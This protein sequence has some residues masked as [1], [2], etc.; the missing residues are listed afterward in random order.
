MF[1]FPENP[2]SIRQCWESAEKL[3]KFLIPTI[4]VT[5]IISV[6]WWVLPYFIL[7]R[8]NTSQIHIINRIIVENILF[9]PIYFL[10]ILYLIAMIYNQ[11]KFAIRGEKPT[12]SHLLLLSAKGLLKLIPALLIALILAAGG[13]ILLIVPGIYVTLALIIYYP[14]IIIDD[15]D[16][17]T[18]MRHVLELIKNHWWFT[19]GVIGIPVLAF[20]GIVIVI[21]HYTIG[22][23]MNAINNTVSLKI[24]FLHHIVRIIFSA[25]FYPLLVSLIITQFHNLKLIYQQTGVNPNATTAEQPIVD[26][27]G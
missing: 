25:F 21:E 2:M 6:I 17:V 18:A 20:W 11:A 26:E 8:L 23:G 27:N 5:A 7:L 14:A 12:L 22:V 24:W 19:F 4:Q 16:P 15:M 10:G 1:E 9:V 3:W 13:Y